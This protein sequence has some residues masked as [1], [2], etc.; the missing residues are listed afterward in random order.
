MPGNDLRDIS[1]KYATD[2]LRLFDN[3]A[4]LNPPVIESR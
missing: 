1:R 2:R 3:A 4:G